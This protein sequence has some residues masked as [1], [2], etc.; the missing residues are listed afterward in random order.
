M[1]QLTI[2]DFFE[3]LKKENGNL[4]HYRYFCNKTHGF[5]QNNECCEE[6]IYTIK[7]MVAI[8]DH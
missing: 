1:K 3:L 2:Y 4:F 8:H 5:F 6:I 7:N